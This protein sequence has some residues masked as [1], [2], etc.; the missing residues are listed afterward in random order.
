M[1]II[2]RLSPAIFVTDFT[3]LDEISHKRKFCTAIV[4]IRYWVVC[5]G[6]GN[7]ALF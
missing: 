4:W 3:H 7:T 2:L 1:S 6:I 5:G